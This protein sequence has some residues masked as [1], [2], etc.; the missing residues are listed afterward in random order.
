MRHEFFI[1]MAHPP[2]VTH[3]EKD[4]T[5]VMKDGKPKPRVYEGAELKAVR[6]LFMDHFA[7]HTPEQK[8]T[9]ALQC[10]IKWCY[11][12]D[13]KHPPGTWKITKP[14][15]DNLVKLIL[16]CCTSLG[17]WKDDALISSLIVQKFYDNI[18]GIYVCIENIGDDA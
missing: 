15:C 11:P 18:P 3:Q 8:F 13:W 6:Q 9:G 10:V 2:D 5:F 16:D 12:A 14:D 7:G 1:P 17:F 4:I